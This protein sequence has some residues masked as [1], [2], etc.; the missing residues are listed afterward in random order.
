MLRD[1]GTTLRPDAG[2][3]PNPLPAPFPTSVFTVVAQQGNETQVACTGGSRSAVEVIR[4]PVRVSF[5]SRAAEVFVAQISGGACGS[6]TGG[7]NRL[8]TIANGELYL[9]DGYALY[10]RGS[11]VVVSGVRL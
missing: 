7:Q 6:V 8:D 10:L 5:I 4:G 1:V 2:A 3:Q 9:A 11:E